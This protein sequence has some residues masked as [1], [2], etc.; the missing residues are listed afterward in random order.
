MRQV[1]PILLLLLVVVGTGGAVYAKWP[2]PALPL[3]I[4]FAGLLLLH[5][6]TFA[7]LTRLERQPA[8]APS[9]RRGRASATPSRKSRKHKRIGTSKSASVVPGRVVKPSPH[10]PL[11]PPD[12]SPEEQEKVEEFLKVVLD[13]A[14]ESEEVSFLPPYASDEGGDSPS[15]GPDSAELQGPAEF[16]AEEPYAEAAGVP[17]DRA[18]YGNVPIPRHFALG[19]VAIIRGALTPSQVAEILVE[20]RKWPKE[21]FGEVAV[22]LGFLTHEELEELLVAQQQGL[23]TDEEIQEARTRIRG[24][25]ALESASPTS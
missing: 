9:S 4:G 21:R 5:L 1:R 18:A 6:H 2:D 3:A 7:R 19:T 16:D 11:D 20:Q 8:P 17:E 25:R 13:D 15:F 22:E 23:F 14:P 10:D 24:F 12:A